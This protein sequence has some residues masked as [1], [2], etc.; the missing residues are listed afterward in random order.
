MAKAATRRQ[1]EMALTVIIQALGTVW[2]SP[3]DVAPCGTEFKDNGQK[4]SGRAGVQEARQ[5][6]CT[7]L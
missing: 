2:V 4:S 6:H 5:D 7:V 3:V 1:A